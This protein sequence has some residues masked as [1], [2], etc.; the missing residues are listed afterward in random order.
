[1]GE[2]GLGWDAGAKKLDCSDDQWKRKIDACDQLYGDVASGEDCV[3]PSMDL[4]TFMEVPYDNVEVE[5]V[6]SD[7]DPDGHQD[8][9]QVQKREA[10]ENEESGFF[11]S[12]ID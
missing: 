5:D 4:E 7:D 11:K 10:F 12:L 2:M 1:I 8:G 6:E 3:S 9:T